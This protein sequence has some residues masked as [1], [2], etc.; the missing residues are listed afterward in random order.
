MF[1]FYRGML[2]IM[3]GYEKGISR[4]AEYVRKLHEATGKILRRRLNRSFRTGGSEL[5]VG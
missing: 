2:G 4:S 1:V 3:C 5:I